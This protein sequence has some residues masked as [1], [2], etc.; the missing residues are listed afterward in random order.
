MGIHGSPECERIRDKAI[1]TLMVAASV[2]ATGCATWKWEM[3]L[4]RG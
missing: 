2:P 3:R 4:D 1:H